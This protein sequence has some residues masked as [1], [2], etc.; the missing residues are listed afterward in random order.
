MGGVTALRGQAVPTVITCAILLASL[1][2][3]ATRSTNMI[4]T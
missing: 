2:L 1:K 4:L 3:S